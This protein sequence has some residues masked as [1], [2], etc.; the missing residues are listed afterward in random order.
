VE[1]RPLGA[2]EWRELKELRLRALAVDPLAFG[3]TLAEEAAYA[4]SEWVE[5]AEESDRGDQGRTFVAID[6]G[7]W[8]GMVFSSLLDEGS[9]GLFGMWVDPRARRMG[10]ARALV[11]A[12]IGWAR[13]RQAP[14][15]T[16][17]VAED[18]MAAQR[19]FGSSGFAPTGE[20][21]PLPSRPHI[22]TLGMHLALDSS[23]QRGRARPSPRPGRVAPE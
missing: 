15:I 8:Q 6:D 1:V 16:L 9:A 5:W 19:L 13:Q 22:S 18:N 3:S 2:S 21:R 10:A 20:R 14:G 17:S 11:N 12:V 23:A 4:D 7:V